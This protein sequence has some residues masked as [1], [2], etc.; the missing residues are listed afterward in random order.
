VHDLT[1][2]ERWIVEGRV[3]RE[4]KITRDGQS[5]QSLG[6][7]AEL[8]P[9]FDI[10]DS[11][12]R[13]RGPQPAQA[14]APLVPLQPPILTPPGGVKKIGSSGALAGGAADSLGAVPQVAAIGDTDAISAGRGG[15]PTWQKVAIMVV[16]ASGIGYGGIMWQKHY[17][18]PAVIS[19]SGTALE[20]QTPAPP[21]LPQVRP[22]APPVAP[23]V[24]SAPEAGDDD[25]ESGADQM[26]GPVIEPLDSAGAG[27][28]PMS[29]AAQGY[30]ALGQRQYLVAIDLFRREL[31]QSPINGTA[32]FGLAEAY[33]GAGDK[34]AALKAYRRYLAI[35]PFG[36]CAGSARFQIRSLA[37]AKTR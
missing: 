33:R 27:Q 32:L 9:Y 19:S 23:L 30:V 26:R 17:L 3:S 22:A 28:G 24:V 14:P 31:A 6:S 36:P 35:L 10:L 5:W 13:A 16:I 1:L 34:P 21:P 7:I 29:L 12:Q 37:E 11:A 8:A 4:D 2:L 15:A 25:A 18:R 20:P